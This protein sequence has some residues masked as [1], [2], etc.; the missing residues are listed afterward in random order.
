MAQRRSTRSS[1]PSIPLDPQENV[2]N[3][4]RRSDPGARDPGAPGVNRAI[5]AIASGR[6]DSSGNIH[7]LYPG[8]A[9]YDEA[10][11]AR[12][13]IIAQDDEARAAQRAVNAQD[14][15][16]RA[17]QRA[18]IAENAAEIGNVVDNNPILGEGDIIMPPAQQSL[19][20]LMIRAH[21]AR[22]HKARELV[23]NQALKILQ[24]LG[25]GMNFEHA[26]ILTLNLSV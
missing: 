13:A 12:R 5:M 1:G 7:Y 11:A 8:D 21:A 3:P 16:A 6:E 24:S 10:R 9:G 15:A 2:M 4:R 19:D 17:A 26:T 25:D 14:D 20:A 23:M 22:I 18:V